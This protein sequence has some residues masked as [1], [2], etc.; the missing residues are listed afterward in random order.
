[1]SWGLSYKN[2][3]DFDAGN[4]TT[5]YGEAPEDVLNVAKATTRALIDTG[6]VGKDK[7]FSI[8]F[9]GHVNPNHEPVEGSA[10]DWLQISITQK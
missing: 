4:H 7:D 9:S 10:N 2:L 1:M 8:N 5:G 6:V 3:A